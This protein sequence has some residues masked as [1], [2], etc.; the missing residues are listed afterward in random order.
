MI[1]AYALLLF[2]C[3]WGNDLYA[4]PKAVAVCAAVLGAFYREP[5]TVWPYDLRPWGALAAALAVSTLF[6]WD[7]G[8]SFVS[9]DHARGLGL[10]QWA[11]CA[12]LFAHGLNTPREDLGKAVLWGG[13]LAALLTLA[14]RALLDG[15]ASW[16]STQGSPVLLGEMLAVCFPIAWRVHPALAALFV[17]VAAAAECR[18]ALL[19]MG[20]AGAYL[21]WRS[22]R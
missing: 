4:L 7:P 21:A 1:A 15:R 3:P 6:S 9:V 22:R 11:I 20:A 2:F 5:P 16:K 10:L 18:S 13:G 12:L 14:Q 17:V 19:A 8:Y